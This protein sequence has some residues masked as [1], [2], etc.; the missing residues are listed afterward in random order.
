MKLYVKVFATLRAKY[1]NI[2]DLNPLEIDVEPGISVSELIHK[3]G[4]E[5]ANIHLILLNGK[6]VDFKTLIK[7]EKS[8]I[9]LFPPIG[10]G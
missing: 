8:T 3:L 5:E 7:E 6:K 10:G 1:P 2:N 9:A 4:F